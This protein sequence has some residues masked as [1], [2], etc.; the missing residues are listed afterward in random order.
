M[1]IIG[2]DIIDRQTK[3]IVGHAKTRA[4]A[5]R[6]VDRRDNEYGGYRFRADP[7]YCPVELSLFNAVKS[8]LGV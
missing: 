2:Y 4:G 8:A 6:S 1:K 3:T 7:V 5:T